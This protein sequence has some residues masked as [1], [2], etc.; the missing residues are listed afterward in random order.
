[1]MS[2]TRKIR[3]FISYTESD[4]A[5]AE[6]VAA[7]IREAGHT[8]IMQHYDSPP[9]DNFV[10]WVN[11]QL[12]TADLVMP[13]YSRQYFESQWC[14]IEWSSALSA[15][16]RMIPLKIRP[17]ALPAVLTHI[18]YV[19]V[20]KRSEKN[21]RRLLN[22]GLGVS[23]KAAKTTHPAQSPAARSTAVVRAWRKASLMA[24]ALGLI[25]SA[26][27][28]DPNGPDTSGDAATD[29]TAGPFS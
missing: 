6:W 29:F 14:T 27:I 20:S 21:I 12:E 1:M 17:C 5:W 13:L 3:I 8:V 28:F 24:A 16:K 7:R 23:G 26:V 10:V 25:G 15:G 9:G 11:R 18:T 19:D 4:L 22:A 2:E